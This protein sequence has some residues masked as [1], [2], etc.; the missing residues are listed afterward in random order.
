MRLVR[1]RV[2]NYKV[3]DDTSDV[4]V[5]PAVTALVGINESGK[6]AILKALWKSRN[7]ASEEFDKQLDYPRARWSTERKK[8][9]YVTHLTYELNDEEQQELASQFPPRGTPVAG[10]QSRNQLRP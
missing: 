3:I 10:T 4:A 6:T 1:F 9:Q 8:S 2:T 5:D 7:A